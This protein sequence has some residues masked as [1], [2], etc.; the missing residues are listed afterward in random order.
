MTIDSQYKDLL[1]EI[2]FGDDSYSYPDVKRDGEI[3]HQVNDYRLKHDMRKG[4]PLLQIK[5]VSMK[6]IITEL[7]WFLRGSSSI[8]YLNKRGCNIWNED[9]RNYV[10]RYSTRD[11][12]EYSVE[13]YGALIKQFLDQK[14]EELGYVNRKLLDAGH[15]YG[16]KWRHWT[17][18]DR[19]GDELT[20]DPLA[21]VINTLKKAPINRRSI[22]N[23]W[24][25][26]SVNEVNSALPPCHWAFEILPYKLQDEEGYGFDL[27]W[28]QRS[29][30]T[31]LGL[32]Y[33]IASYGALM[34]II[35]KLTGFKPRFLIGDLSNVHIYNSHV[36]AVN[37]LLDR[38]VGENITQLSINKDIST[39]E[40]AMELEF[41][42]FE[43]TNY[44]P[45]GFVGAKMLAI[46]NPD[47]NK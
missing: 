30:D 37:K 24:D 39:L 34:L 11:D 31:F 21:N 26:I 7:I 28:H 22:I 40:Q 16:V 29:V 47:W 17:G 20:V 18:V 3:C 1:N 12:I 2:L 36:D 5:K 41:E 27:K 10:N 32:P 45:Q 46:T 43:L 33:N 14:E 42:D 15:I 13:E 9:V 25:A 19:Y 35:E 8:H 44:K 4:F 6:N 38:E 23:A